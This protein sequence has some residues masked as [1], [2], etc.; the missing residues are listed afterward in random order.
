MRRWSDKEG[1]RRSF[2]SNMLL[3]YILLEKESKAVVW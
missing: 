1:K 2:G 3:G